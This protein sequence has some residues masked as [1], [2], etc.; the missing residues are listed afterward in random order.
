MSSSSVSLLRASTS[1]RT[2]P[3]NRRRL[4]SRSTA[5]SRSSASSE[6][7]KSASRVTRNSTR[8]VISIPGNTRPRLAA[9]T[10]STGTS[11]SP[12]RTNRGSMRGTFTRA[13][14]DSPVCGSRT[15]SPR[16]RDRP[17]M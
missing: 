7:E 8:R 14:R 5:F 4:S 17:L 10:C 6:I 15:V 16:F 2:G 12:P 13:N 1:T 3:P 11:M 9:I